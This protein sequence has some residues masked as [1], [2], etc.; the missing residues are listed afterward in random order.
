M[1]RNQYNDLDAGLVYFLALIT[2]L[3]VGLVFSLIFNLIAN[4]YGFINFSGSP[5]LTALY[6]CIVVLSFL[7]LFFVYNKVGKVSYK[8]ASL[9]KLK[10]GLK[11]LVL[12][13]MIAFVTLFGFNYLINY[14]FYLLEKIGYSPDA[15]LPLPLNNGWWL[16]INLFVLAVVP[17]FCEEIIYRGIILNGFRRFG[18][19]NAILI[20]ALFFALAHGS[21][22]QF[23][24]QF[25]LGIILGF[26]L[27]KTGSII[28]S[29]LVHF[30]NNAIV[31]VYNYIAPTQ[32]SNFGTTSIIASFA[33][34]IAAT[35][36]LILLIYSLKEKKSVQISY[37]EEYNRLYP[38]KDKNFSSSQSKTI[39]WIS[40]VISVILWSVGTFLG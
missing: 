28:A 40:I 30:L 20:S 39:F 21:A 31:I 26:V 23:I 24:Y 10:F 12:C 3:V 9:F 22:M 2:P 29:M 33:L 4:R 13:I 15:S 34:A 6:L 25:I 37:N 14:L 17:A 38:Q 7:G 11:N 8:Q 18:K 32:T 5:V 1:K 35:A 16:T 27:V 36:L 19:V